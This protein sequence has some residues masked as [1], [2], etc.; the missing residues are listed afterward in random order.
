[1]QT[2]EE[3][4][5]R[6]TMSFAHAPR[7]FAGRLSRVQKSATLQVLSIAQQ[8]KAEGVRIIDLGAGEPDFSTPEHIKE[9]AKRALDANFTRYT[10][11]GGVP[12]LRDAI[13][14]RLRQ[15]FGV[16]RTRF[17]II[18]TAGAKQAIF[19][20]LL[21]IIGEGDEVVIPSP[22]WGTFPQVVHICGGNP[23]IAEAA[24][25]DK[26]S[27]TA[28]LLQRHFTARTKAIILNSPHNPTGNVIARD[29]FLKICRLAAERGIFVVSDECYMGFVYDGLKAYTGAMVPD[30]LRPWVI[31]AGSLSKI[32]AMTGW[33]IGYVIGPRDL[34][35]KM[36]T[37]QGHQ[38]SNPTS[39]SQAAAIE[40]LTGSQDSAAHM[41]KEYQRRRDFLIPALNRIPGFHCLLPQG[42]FYAYPDIRKVLIGRY[43]TSDEF[44]RLLLQEEHIAVT[45]GSGFGT[46]GFIRISYTAP[47]DALKEAIERLKDFINRT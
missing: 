36:D 21:T 35:S 26:F 45:P 10:A 15:D 44:A 40:A 32:Y 28:D 20:A 7:S 19:N 41:I 24:Y 42:A 8:L 12:E 18:A 43:K 25:E 1:V 11:P 38:T 5:K 31:V 9:A 46:E 34:I 22:Y 2:E 23:I 13:I 47:L 29:E 37:I 27:V 16:E 39:V 6:K 4:L 14:A 17:E 30:E 33:R 3:F